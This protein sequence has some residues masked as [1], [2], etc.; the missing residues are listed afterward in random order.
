MVINYTVTII[1]DLQKSAKETNYTG[2]Y[3]LNSSS[4]RF[5]LMAHPLGFTMSFGL[6]GTG[7]H[8]VERIYL[9]RKLVRSVKIGF[10]QGRCSFAADRKSCIDTTSNR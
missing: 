2:T 10:Q 5:R 3:T 1:F 9:I 7:Q 4:C 8:P 6:W